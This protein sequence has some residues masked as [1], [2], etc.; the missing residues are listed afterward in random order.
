[1]KLH[2]L[3]VSCIRGA[4]IVIEKSGESPTQSTRRVVYIS[5]ELLSERHDVV[6]SNFCTAI[7]IKEGLD[8]KYVY[9]YLQLSYNAGVCFNFEGNT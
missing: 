4:N 8:A 1:M 7:R 5:E 9:Y 3:A 2:L 6:C